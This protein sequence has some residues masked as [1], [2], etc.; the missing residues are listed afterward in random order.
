MKTPLKK[1]WTNIIQV[2]SDIKIMNKI[3]VNRSPYY[4]KENNIIK[5]GITQGMQG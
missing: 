4:L 5:I 2:N 3:S 1:L